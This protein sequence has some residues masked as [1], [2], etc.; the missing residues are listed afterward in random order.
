MKDSAHHL[1]DYTGNALVLSSHS[2]EAYS[3]TKDFTKVFLKEAETFL[4]GFHA[5][6]SL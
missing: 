2:D 6:V 3:Q 4:K 1:A 5:Y